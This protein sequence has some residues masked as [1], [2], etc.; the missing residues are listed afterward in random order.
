MENQFPAKTTASTGIQGST[1]PNALF[2]DLLSEPVVIFPYRKESQS[3][4]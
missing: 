2:Y 1:D 3:W 4:S